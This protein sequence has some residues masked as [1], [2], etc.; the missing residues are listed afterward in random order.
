MQYIRKKITAMKCLL[1]LTFILLFS[2]LCLQAQWRL[3]PDLGLNLSNIR[4]SQN[5]LYTPNSLQPGAKLGL[6]ADKEFNDNFAIQ[7][8]AYFAM[9]GCYTAGSN[10]YSYGQTIIVPNTTTIINYIQVP[11]NFV[12]KAGLGSGRVFMGGGA[13]AGYAVNG[14]IKQDGYNI[15]AF[16]S[17]T[18]NT[19][20]KFGSDT[21]NFKALDY[22]LQIIAGYEL[23]RGLF[24]KA[25]YSYGFSNFSNSSA[26][27]LNNT[28]I[29]L[30]IGYLF[31]GQFYR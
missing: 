10:T 26:I 25:A 3:G 22:G 6:L 9:M 4:Q 27:T 7:L 20:I 17:N 1:S 14:N 13:Y 16:S 2:P 5:S 24:F 8:G 19:A 29:Y 21:S 18:T 28:C 31:G 11:V 15:G 12:Y 23:P 30:G